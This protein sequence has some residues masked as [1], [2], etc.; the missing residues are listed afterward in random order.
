MMDFTILISKIFVRDFNLKISV[1][2]FNLEWNTSDLCHSADCIWPYMKPL[3][4]NVHIFC[5][6]RLHNQSANPTEKGKLRLKKIVLSTCYLPRSTLSL[7][8][9]YLK[10][11][12]KF[13]LLLLASESCFRA[14][15]QITDQ[16]EIAYHY[17][18]KLWNGIGIVF[19]YWL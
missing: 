7:V 13:F 10:K 18:M 1:M 11:Y 5:C 17:E 3:S 4:T 12:L 9:C 8:N 15:R 14:Y 6:H 16:Q 2:D 19:S